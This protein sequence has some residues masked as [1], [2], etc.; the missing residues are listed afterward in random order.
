MNKE[1]LKTDQDKLDAFKKA[2]ENNTF[3]IDNSCI[4]EALLEA[5]KYTKKDRSNVE[6]PELA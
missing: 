3:P 4:A 1:S 2:L 5:Q 6:E